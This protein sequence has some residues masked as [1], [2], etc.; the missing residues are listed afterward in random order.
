M[1]A[2][3]SGSKRVS[4]NRTSSC[5]G[6]VVWLHAARS[7]SDRLWLVQQRADRCRARASRELGQ[8]RLRVVAQLGEQLFDRLGPRWS[9]RANPPTFMAME[10]RRGRAPSW[11]S[12]SILRRAASDAATIGA[13]ERLQVGVGLP[14]LLEAGLQRG[15]E[16]AVVDGLR[17]HWPGDVGEHVFLGF[18]PLAPLCRPVGIPRLRPARRRARAAQAVFV[19]VAECNQRHP[20]REPRVTRGLSA[21]G[22]ICASSGVSRNG[23]ASRC[24]IAPT[25]NNSSCCPPTPRPTRTADAPGAARPAAGAAPRGAAPASCCAPKVRKLSPVSVR[26][27][28]ATQFASELSRPATAGRAATGR[29][30]RERQDEHGALVVVG[31]VAEPDDDDDDAG[32]NERTREHRLGRCPLHTNRRD[33]TRAAASVAAV[34]GEAAVSTGPT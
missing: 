21:R 28:N 33:G 2:S 23:S 29:G 9:W 5:T 25:R 6:N 8:R 4:P 11:R 30:S 3:I 16:L 26:S 19:P 10:T 18:G 13:R 14:Q 15:V 27:P 34:I 31:P 24:G 7:A 32:E 17:W 20:H 22:T 1:V 12:R